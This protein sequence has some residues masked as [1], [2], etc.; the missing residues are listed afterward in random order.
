[1]RYWIFDLD[2][3]LVDSFHYYFLALDNLLQKEGLALTQDL[4]REALREHP[5]KF[6]AK[7][8]SA[9]HL[10]FALDSLVALSRSDAEIIKAYD[11]M[12]DC[13]EL[14]K[15]QEAKV[16]IWTSRPME[17]S[18]IIINSSGLAPYIDFHLSGD[19][20][21]KPKPDSEGLLNIAKLFECNP[22][23]IYMVGDHEHDMLAAKNAGAKGIR[24]SWHGHWQEA[25]CVLGD[26]QFHCSKEF[27]Q[28]LSNILKVSSL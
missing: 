16:A 10:P 27:V 25:E 9:D 26:E 1:M 2:G 15:S 11:H 17:S 5:A 22:S 18:K 12:L 20:V 19:C 21:S 4:K 24:A 23:E 8:L 7:Y 14:L 3:T 13:L 6:L 28:W